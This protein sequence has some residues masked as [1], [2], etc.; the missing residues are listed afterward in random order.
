MTFALPAALALALLVAQPEA[1]PPPAAAAVAL[2]AAQPGRQLQAAQALGEWLV[3]AQKSGASLPRL[4]DPGLAG[5]LVAAAFD[6]A[7]IT[8]TADSGVQLA[9]LCTTAQQLLTLYLRDGVPTQATSAQDQLNR[10]NGNTVRFQDE[11]ALA[12]DFTLDCTARMIT[13]ATKSYAQSPAV[14]RTDAAR[15]QTLR[16]LQTLLISQL[17]GGVNTVVSPAY[18]ARFRQTILTALNRNAALYAGA[19]TLAQRGSLTEGLDRAARTAGPD[20][21]AGLTRL[22]AT[23][24]AAP[25][26][27][28]CQY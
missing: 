22:R 23:I 24:G 27:G 13:L 26:D 19:L 20:Y 5:R 4:A 14:E 25:C 1:P 6:K 15:T 18:E 21:E 11:E 9:N 7:A 8:A 12:M 16:Q 17:R 28:L 3:E 10:L 2:G